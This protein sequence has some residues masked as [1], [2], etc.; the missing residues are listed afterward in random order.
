[1][2]RDEATAPKSD[3]EM[4]MGDDDD[5]VLGCKGGLGRRPAATTSTQPSSR[6]NMPT[7]TDRAQNSCSS[8]AGTRNLKL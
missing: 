5:D 7:P 3:G 8:C 6:R 4:S 2:M 1:M